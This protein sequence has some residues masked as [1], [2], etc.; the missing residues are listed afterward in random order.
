MEMELFLILF[1]FYQYQEE[2]WVARIPC[3]IESTPNQ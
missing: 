1:V 2:I 3:I